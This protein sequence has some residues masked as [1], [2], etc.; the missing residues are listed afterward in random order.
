LADSFTTTD[1]ANLDQD[2]NTRQ[3]GNAKP[4]SF[5][6][7]GTTLSTVAISGGQIAITNSPT[8]SDPANGMVSPDVDFRQLEHLNS[9]RMKFTAFGTNST[10]NNNTWIGVRWRDTRTGRF[11]NSG[12]GGGNGLNLF[13][14]G[15]WYFHQTSNLVAH[16]TIPVA[17]AYVFEMEVRTAWTEQ[18]AF[19]AQEARLGGVFS[20][21]Q[22]EAVKIGQ[23]RMKGKCYDAFVSVQAYADNGAEDRALL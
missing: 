8:G 12:N 11:L 18:A 14:D 17:S 23:V 22:G 15:S 7:G 13:P 19:G 21:L 4:I 5:V 16:G 20:V 3:T 9:Y 10:A 1:T 2:L 6:T